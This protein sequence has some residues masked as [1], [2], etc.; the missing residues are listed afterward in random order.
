MPTKQGDITILNNPIAQELLHSKV[1]ARLAYVWPDGT[2]RVIPIW[3]HWNGQEIVMG[4]PLNAP[5]VKALDEGSKVALTID[6]DTWPHKVLQIRGTV[7]IETVDGVVPEY[8][9][10]AERYLGAEG[11]KGWVE[12]AKALFPQMTRIVV[13][14]DWVG[15]LD[16]E[17]RF[18]SAIEA[19][20]AG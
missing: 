2:P 8:A 11:G 19:A 14:P 10:A 18:P 5:K 12:Q 4:T 13:R 20:M 9:L 16:F 6:T 3:F 17:Q 15:L 7:S 1:P